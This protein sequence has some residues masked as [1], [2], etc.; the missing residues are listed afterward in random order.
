MS[1]HKGARLMMDALP[2]AFSLL[3]DK[4]YDSNWFRHALFD[5]GIEPYIPPTK[6]RKKS[7]DYNETLYR[8][9][10]KPENVFAN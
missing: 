10:H 3:G 9:R 6:S 5:K 8:Q 7:I 1:D 4:G 2:T